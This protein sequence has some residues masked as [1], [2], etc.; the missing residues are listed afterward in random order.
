YY[1]GSLDLLAPGL[2]QYYQAVLDGI[3]SFYPRLAHFWE[4]SPFA[5]CCF[6]LRPRVWAFIHTDHFNIPFGWCS[7]TALGRFCPQR[8]GHLIL[9]DWGLII[10]FPHGST[11]YIPSALVQHSNIPV[12]AHET[13]FSIVQWMPGP[14]CLWFDY[15]FRSSKSFLAEHG[16]AKVADANAAHWAE[17]L[18][19]LSKLRDFHQH[20][21]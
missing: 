20:G 19:L 7:I 4:C 3:C 16:K 2:F 21:Q 1:E 5:C 18:K 14:L 6:N 13:R 17:G 8:S 11:I 15:G 9:W 10:D 12:Q